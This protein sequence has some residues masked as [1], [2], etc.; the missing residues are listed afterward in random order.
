MHDEAEAAVTPDVSIIDEPILPDHRRYDP[1]DADR[2]LAQV[3]GALFSRRAAPTKIGRFVL[4][5]RVGAGGMG[6]VYAAYDPKLD[7]KI[8]IKVLRPGEDGD[9]VDPSALLAEARALA[10]LTHPNVVTVFE[11]GTLDDHDEAQ[12]FLAMEFVDGATLHNWVAEPRAPE[13]IRRAAVEVCKGLAAAHAVGIVHGDIKPANVA[14]TEGD[15]AI[16]LDFGLARMPERP[17]AEG[18]RTSANGVLGGDPTSSRAGGTPAYMAP[19]VLQGA[20]P[21]AK[22]DQYALCVTMYEVVNQR[23]PYDAVSLAGLLEAMQSTA[24]PPS[25]VGVPSWLHA[26]LVRGLSLD[27]S[28]RW[29]SVE[30][31]AVELAR[32][33]ASLARPALIVGTT[34]AVA[35]GLYG[36]ADRTDPCALA[37]QAVARLWSEQTRA[38]V[39]TSLEDVTDPGATTAVLEGLDAYA[40]ALADAELQRCRASEVAGRAH[41]VTDAC[42]DSLTET[43]EAAVAML[44]APNDRVLADPRRVL[45]S[46]EALAACRQP[47]SRSP[48][49]S[50]ERREAERALSRATIMI[51]AG[52]VKEGLAAAASILGQAHARDEPGLAARAGVGVGR[53]LLVLGR[54]VDAVDVLQSALVEAERVDEPLARTAALREL[55]QAL[56]K[57]A[58]LDA[59]ERVAAQ[60]AA[61]QSRFTQR[62]AAWD[63]Q[64]AETQADIAMAR[65]R[66]EDALALYRRAAEITASPRVPSAANTSARSGVAAALIRLRRFDE[67]LLEYNE[68]RTQLLERRGP[69]HIGLAVIDNNLGIISMSNRDYA[70]ARDAF[71]RALEQ[72][73]RVLGPEDASLSGV[74]VNLGSIT[75][76]TDP[77]A[78]VPILRRALLTG[79]SAHG[80]GSRR[81]AKA[82]YALGRALLTL[83]ML[84]EAEESFAAAMKIHA[85]LGGPSDA[86]RLVA[87]VRLAQTNIAEEQCTEALPL[88]ADVIA[89][90]DT[91]KHHHREPWLYALAGSAR[92]KLRLSESAAALDLSE[93]AWLA[94]E[95]SNLTGEAVAEVAVT[96]A[97]VYARRGRPFDELVDRARRESADGRTPQPQLLRRLEALSSQ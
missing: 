97:E 23:R 84:D 90:V 31:L 6:T 82:H 78:A 12:I 16:V 32:N 15:R 42:L 85:E 18:E 37:G 51:D 65:T 92:C 46:V 79:V 9:D 50:E 13:L 96:L 1:L 53:A 77:A 10:K 14:I 93:R 47:T 5:E 41:P 72:R 69:D 76:R 67:A 62:P 54:P 43:L 30:A 89:H 60:A 3:T 70:G 20:L 57:T 81:V 91:D 40:A 19:E 22:S 58:Q 36:I 8:A 59:A 45:P 35:G 21:T 27:P 7:R 83:D 88:L 56:A 34:L 52:E 17:D 68:L 29:D 44:V 71:G 61:A 2:V 24:V 49:I 39:S 55:A 95:G 75:M 38:E 33:R 4:L 74:L 28:D 66:Y 87:A 80:P 64:L 63:Y 25:N 48:A 94:C 73:E 26:A 11:V 86:E